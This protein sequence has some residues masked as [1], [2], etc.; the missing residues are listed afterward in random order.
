MSE[1]PDLE[2]RLRR[3]LDAVAAT[4][5][6]GAPRSRPVKRRRGRAPVV[7][8]GTLAAAALVIVLVLVNGPSRDNT[9]VRTGEPVSTTVEVGL[10]AIPGMMAVAD[11]S[12]HPVGYVRRSDIDIPFREYA[13]RVNAQTMFPVT[14][15]EGTI[16]GYLAPD[17]PFIPLSVVQAPG[18]DI[19]KV[20][21]AREG[22]CEMRVGD[23]NF[24]Q[25]FPL[26]P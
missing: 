5:V 15:A 21:A 24:T 8:F 22:G 1:A 9:K 25:E 20:R 10:R 18:F 11:E 19:E 2:D 6:A 3:T 26:C 7:A 13:K 4:T 16:V 23:P 14:D 17:V 12:G